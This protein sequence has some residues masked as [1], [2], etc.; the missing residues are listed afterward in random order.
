MD[1]PLG[2]GRGPNGRRRRKTGY[3]DTQA[4]AVSLLHKFGGRAAQGP[5][6]GHQ[7][8]DSADIPRGLVRDPQR[9]VAAE[10]AAELSGHHRPVSDAGVRADPARAP[11]PAMVQR[12]LTEHKQAHGARRRMTLAHATLRSALSAAQ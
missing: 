9:R 10:H 11:V 6:P 1:G 2:P 7:Y 12:W 4:E 5:T 3:A 8:S